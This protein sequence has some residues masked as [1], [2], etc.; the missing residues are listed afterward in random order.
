MFASAL[1]RI[2]SST[3]AFEARACLVVETIRQ[4]GSLL[5]HVRRRLEVGEEGL[6][7]DRLHHPAGRRSQRRVRRD[8]A[9][10]LATAVLARE[11][12]DHRVRVLGEAHL[13]LAVRLVASASVEDEHASRAAGR[14]PARERV[15]EL[16][17]LGEA[18][19]VEEVVPVEEVQRR[20]GDVQQTTP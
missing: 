19:G 20:V 18:A 9:H 8:D 15:A 13:E 3:Q 1:L 11:P 14:D 2:L 6:R 5:L 10:A 7:R 16:A 4:L 17:Q 12:L